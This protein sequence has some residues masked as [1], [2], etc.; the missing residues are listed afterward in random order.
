MTRIAAIAALS[1]LL[2]TPTIQAQPEWYVHAGGVSHHFEETRAANRQWQEQHAGLGFERRVTQDN[3]WSVRMAGG[4][5]QDSR[6]FW[7]GYSGLGYVHRWRLGEAVELGA[8][9]GAYA[10]YRSTS[11]S[12]QMRVVPAVLPTAS[13]GLADN[14]VGLNIV[15]V[16]RVTA[17]SETM[18]PS[19]HTQLV[20]RFR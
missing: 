17:Y 18:A 12:G 5:M 6:G 3:G 4:V 7:G 9:A 13:V 16:P 8:G 19:L 10:F 11:W 14:A 1:A 2:T 20:V 15:Y